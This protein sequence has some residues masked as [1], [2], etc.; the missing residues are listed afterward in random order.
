[1]TTTSQSANPLKEKFQKRVEVILQKKTMNDDDL[2]Y[3]GDLLGE[4][5]QN[6]DQIMH[7]I[8]E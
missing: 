6:I 1:M 2:D 3:F 7:W 4:D 5:N 8:P